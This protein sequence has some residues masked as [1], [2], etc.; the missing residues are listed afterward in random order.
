MSTRIDPFVRTL[1]PKK[2]MY[3]IAGMQDGNT[4]TKMDK[5]NHHVRKHNAYAMQEDVLEYLIREHVDIVEV[6][7]AKS[8][9][10]FKSTTEDWIVLGFSDNL[11]NG[12][13]RFLNIN[14]MKIFR[15]VE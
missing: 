6:L 12:Q 13:Q 5:G 10:G 14:Y 1:D 7:D 4:F 2:K 15:K 3:V 9:W 8:S 11:G